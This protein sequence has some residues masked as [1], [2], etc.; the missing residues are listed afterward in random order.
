M[1]LGQIGGFRE[2]LADETINCSGL[3]RVIL[4]RKANGRR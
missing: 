4:E 2:L 3:Q 1:M